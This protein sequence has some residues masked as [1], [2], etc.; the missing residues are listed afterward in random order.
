MYWVGTKICSAMNFKIQAAN[1]VKDERYLNFKKRFK[2]FYFRKIVMLLNFCEFDNFYIKNYEFFSRFTDLSHVSKKKLLKI[3]DF[4]KCKLSPTKLFFI[5]LRSYI[6]NF[7]LLSYRGL[8]KKS[9]L[10]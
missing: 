4:L 8:D 6:S 3:F 5:F 7:L 10:T 2:N 9:I 1:F